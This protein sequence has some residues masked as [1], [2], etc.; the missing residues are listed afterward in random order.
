MLKPN[1]ALILGAA[2]SAEVGMPLGKGLKGKIADV[3]PR[4][5]YAPLWIDQGA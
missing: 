3:L 4:E 1:T 2:M 5:Q